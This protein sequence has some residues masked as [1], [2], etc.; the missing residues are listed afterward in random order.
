MPRVRLVL[1][2]LFALLLSRPAHAY[3]DPGTGSMLVQA[4]LAA[5]AAASAVVAASWGRIRRFFSG[6]GKEAPPVDRGDNDAGR[7]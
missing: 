1:V 2:T 7:S 6:G 4:L 3:L 5:L